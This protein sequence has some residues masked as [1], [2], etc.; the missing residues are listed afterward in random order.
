MRLRYLN[1]LT[2]KCVQNA[3]H[4]VRRLEQSVN[5]RQLVDEG[6][7]HGKG[8]Q[9]RPRRLGEVGRVRERVYVVQV[10]DSASQRHLG[11]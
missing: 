1:P 7:R 3:T 8:M 9:G 4:P 6:Q 5:G 10:L 11:N 2:V